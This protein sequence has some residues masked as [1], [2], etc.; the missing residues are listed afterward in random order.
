MIPNLTNIFQ[1]GWN[2]QLVK[3]VIVFD[4]SDLQVKL[5]SLPQRFPSPK[6]PP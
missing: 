5:S 6:K 1:M 2:Q 3:V 4:L